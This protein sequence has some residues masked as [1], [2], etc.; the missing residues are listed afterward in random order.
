VLG[1]KGDEKPSCDNFEKQPMSNSRDMSEMWDK[2]VSDNE[3]LKIL[4]TVTLHDFL[5]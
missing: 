2:D 1:E 4:S 5:E 3:S